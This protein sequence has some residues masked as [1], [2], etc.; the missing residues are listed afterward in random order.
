MRIN[1]TDTGINSIY[2]MSRFQISPELIVPLFILQQSFLI[3]FFLVF[4]IYRYSVLL[5]TLHEDLH[6]SGPNNSPTTEYLHLQ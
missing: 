4:L 6:I 2:V 5:L 3:L 1:I